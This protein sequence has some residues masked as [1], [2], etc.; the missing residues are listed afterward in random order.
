MEDGRLAGAPREERGERKNEELCRSLYKFVIL[1]LKE[2]W[3]VVLLGRCPEET[4]SHMK[5]GWAG[6][7]V[8]IR[9]RRWV[10]TT[11]SVDFSDSSFKLGN[12]LSTIPVK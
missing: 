5:R 7:V 3:K 1:P 10:T 2:G 9:W 11:F 6:N 4:Q 12:F 8:E